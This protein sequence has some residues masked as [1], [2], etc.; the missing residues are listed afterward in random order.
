LAGIEAL[1]RHLIVEL[2]HCN[3]EKLKEKDTVENIMVSASQAGG[4]HTIGVF[5]HQFKPYGVSGVIVIEESHLSIHTWPGYNYAAIDVF[6]CGGGD[7]DAVI[8]TLVEGFESKKYYV[9]AF[10]RGLKD[11]M[12]ETIIPP[13][14]EGGTGEPGE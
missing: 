12:H 9:R 1:G 4:L 6:V 3:P 7:S 5:F 8:A 2:Y 14:E 13:V 10:F 11:E